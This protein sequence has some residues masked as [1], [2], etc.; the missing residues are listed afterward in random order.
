MPPKR[1]DGFQWKRLEAPE[2]SCSYY[3]QDITDDDILIP[4]FSR[5]IFRRDKTRLSGGVCVQVKDN[6]VAT[7]LS[8]YE[9]DGLEMLW[10]RILIND[11]TYILGASYRNPACL[12]E[13]W[14]SLSENISNIVDTFGSQNIIIMGDFN[15]NLLNHN[16]HHLSDLID[17]FNLSQ[18]ITEPTRIT[19]N[20][21]TLLDP[22]IV[23][24]PNLASS[25]G[26][27]G[28]RKL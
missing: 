8:P 22:V 17:S 24:R 5:Q 20:S 4:G 19:L 25:A 6:I 26:V 9:S 16:V 23:G 21:E 10:L 15:E 3:Y 1:L 11:K 14:D 2:L 12:V 18:L 27:G 7:R 13:Y 28:V